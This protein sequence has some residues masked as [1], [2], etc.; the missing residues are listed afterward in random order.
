MHGERLGRFPTVT[1]R[2]EERSGKLR[3]V[4]DIPYQT[5]DGKRD[6]YRHDAQVQTR[7]GAEAEHRRLVTELGRTGT[8]KR[9]AEPS[10]E[11]TEDRRPTFADAARHFK[12]TRL[13]ALK[14]STRVTYTARLETVLMPKFGDVLL[15]DLNGESLLKFDSELVKNELAP[16][17]RRNFHI[18]FR[19]ILRA[20]VDAGLLETMPTMPPMPRVG[21]KVTKPLRR[22][23]L[24][25]ILALASPSARLAFGLAAFAGLRAG[26]IRGLRWSD[27]DLTVG[28]ITIRRSVSRGEESTPKSGHQEVV[29]IVPSLGSLL[30]AAQASRKNLWPNVALTV[31]GKPW[32]EWGLRQV[33]QRVRDRAGLD[34]WSFH[35]L[36]HFFISELFRKRV[37]APAVQALA[38]HSA[39]TTTQR[40]AD[41]DANDLREAINLLDGNGVETVNRDTVVHS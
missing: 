34:T 1:I 15:E 8:L 7:A 30:E 10:K 41:V 36:R 22:G 40:Y 19:S 3:W 33:F 31:K 37:P 11:V 27:I 4:I 13:I 9:I 20:A 2:K 26:E 25:S 35:D 24:D 6:R 5:A 23:D 28:T 32:G 12:T 17:T 16:S 18:L 29:P 21:R 39:L 14:P 38:R